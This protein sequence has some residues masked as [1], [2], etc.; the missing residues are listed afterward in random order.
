M[1]IDDNNVNGLEVNWTFT[2]QLNS[3]EEKFCK[4]CPLCIVQLVTSDEGW[5]DCAVD[6]P[7]PLC[8]AL[9]ILEQELA[10]LHTRHFTEPAP[11]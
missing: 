9:P 11:S 5:I 7:P 10:T 8:L 1:K 3:G 6:W 4:T 2:A